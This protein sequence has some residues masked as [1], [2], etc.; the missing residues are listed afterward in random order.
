VKDVK[1][2]FVPAPGVVRAG[3]WQQLVDGQ[4]ADIGD[5]VASWDYATRLD[6]RCALRIDIDALR[7]DTDLTDGSPL[8]LAV[9]WRCLDTAL[10]GEP[11]VQ[12]LTADHIEMLMT[13]P[14]ERAGSEI[15]LTRRIV[16]RRDRLSPTAGQAKWAGS[17]LWSD[18]SRLR[19]TGDG[20]AFPVEVVAFD[21]VGRNPN[22]SWYLQLPA[23]ADGP[24][25]GSMLLLINSADVDLVAA[26]SKAARHTEAQRLLVN[27]LEEGLVEELV[28]W[29]LSRWDELE[30]L[31]D[32]TVGAVAR[33][34]AARVIPN[35]GAWVSGDHSSMDLRAEIAG[36]A[37][38]LGFGRQLS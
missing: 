18:E 14:P 22:V 38:A 6:L 9:G 31:E 15:V 12:D 13:V 32:E 17:I 10:V 29:A 5:F 7:V 21:E 34:L 33:T 27:Q 2:F 25:M 24:V 16:L 26:V 11:V 1:P 4:W 35:P 3:V 20:S 28:R 19:L 8:G 23:S 36:R 30:S 37:R